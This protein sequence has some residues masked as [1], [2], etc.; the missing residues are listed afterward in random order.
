MGSPSGFRRLTRVDLKGF[1]RQSQN[2]VL[3][4]M[5]RG[6]V[7][8]V[9]NRGHAILRSPSG[10]TMS[11]SRAFS[12]NRGMKNCEAQFMRVFGDL[13]QED[14]RGSLALVPDLHPLVPSEE[15]PMLECPVASCPAEFVTEGA[16][17]SHVHAKH[18]P[19]PEPGCFKVFDEKR[20]AVGHHNVVHA[21]KG[22]VQGEYPCDQ[23]GCTFV[24]K[25]LA[26]IGIH[27]AK[28]HKK[29]GIRK[30]ATLKK[31]AAKKKQ[32]AAKAVAPQRE[33]DLA[34]ELDAALSRIADL[35]NAMARL[36]EALR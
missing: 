31:Q 33:R 12:N 4:A 30:Q 5:E 21:K 18:F 26:G 23:R 24:G 27:R 10:S 34:A 3:M 1:S 19:C 11:V 16:R 35:E 28:I 9:S 17:Y 29:P 20:K 13:P 8:R 15:H 7:G 14:T 22:H 36:R 32:S 25:T 6:G 2:L